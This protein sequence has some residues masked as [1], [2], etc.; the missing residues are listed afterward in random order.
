VRVLADGRWWDGDLEA[1]RR[2]PDGKWLGWV[3]WTE[4]IAVTRIGWFGEG[5]LESVL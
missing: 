5:E 2:E 3:R 4:S 1:Y